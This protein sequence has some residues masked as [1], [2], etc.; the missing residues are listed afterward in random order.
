MHQILYVGWVGFGNLG[1]EL[2]WN[3]FDDLSRRYFDKNKV[4]ITPSLPYVDVNR[5]D[6]Y[7]LVVLGGGSIIAPYYLGILRKAL[8]QGKK[9]AI[10]GSGIDW[11]T[12]EFLRCLLS[13]DKF[14]Y[15]PFYDGFV[16]LLSEIVHHSTYTGVRGPLTYDT[17]KRL[18]IDMEKVEICGDPGLLVPVTE[19]EYPHSEELINWD[20]EKIIGLNWGTTFND[21]YGH[22]ESVVEEQLVE[23]VHHFIK[24]G[25]KIFL[26]DVWQED[27]QHST[28]L[29]E[30]ITDKSKVYR[31][32]KLYNQYELV[33]KLRHCCFTV[34]F[35]LH[36]NV[37]SVVAGVP[38]IALGYRFKI[39]DF[40][41]S[42]GLPNIAV[43]TDSPNLTDEICTLSEY[44]TSHRAE[45]TEL[46]NTYSNHYHVKLERPFQHTFFL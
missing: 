31:A 4:Q 38:F 36:A 25:Y 18:G 37:L 28:R 14:P 35:K 6:S 39:F 17:M 41:Q 8:E 20:D 43:P 12:K 32:K 34:N 1:D 3:V 10:W 2:L 42:I 22:N 40:V 26:Y 27:V 15:Q 30:K 44:V 45:I 33:Q 24:Q 23:A 19:Q 29:Y 7:D 9:V 11:Q 16:E 46:F 13:G 5:L 21:I